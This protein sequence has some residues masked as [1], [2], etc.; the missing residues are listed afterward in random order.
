MEEELT[1]MEDERVLELCEEKVG[2][3]DVQAAITDGGK[4][5]AQRVA[6]AISG[7]VRKLLLS[8]QGNFVVQKLIEVLPP[9]DHAFIAKEIR[10]HAAAM[11]K[12][13]TGCRG[14]CRLLEHSPKAPGTQAVV[15]ELLKEDKD[16]E[17]TSICGLSKHAFA[18]YVIQSILENGLEEQKR[19]V[20]LALQA[21]LTRMASHKAASYV[22]EKALKHCDLEVQAGLLKGLVEPERV[23]ALAVTR[24]VYVLI[25]IAERSKELQDAVREAFPVEWRSSEEG[26]KLEAS[27]HGKILLQKLGLHCGE[28][29]E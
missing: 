6:A 26:K 2:C 28:P 22:V 29:S 8:Q 21:D 16:D 7:N 5:V 3:R 11:A 10:G 23:R 27:K 4:K 17:R 14:I 18:H 20:G 15:E 25:S 1:V 9:G 12:S 19:R 24:G 13:Q